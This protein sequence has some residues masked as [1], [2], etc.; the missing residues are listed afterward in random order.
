MIRHLKDRGIE[1]KTDWIGLA[2]SA[3]YGS[4]KEWLPGNY[5]ET[6]R[7][8]TDEFPG[9]HVLLFGSQNEA[10]K[11]DALCRGIDGRVHNLAG[12]LS[13]RQSIEAISLCRLFISND[14]G[15]MHV[16]ASLSIPQVAIFGPTQPHKTAPTSP[17]ARILHHPVHCAPCLHRQCPAGH[18]CMSSVTVAELMEAVD[19]LWQEYPERTEGR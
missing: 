13:L 17:K 9:C 7:Q 8:L 19:A 12:T 18:E 10:R 15:L 11:I 1:R 4:A 5:R 3:A 6:I 2:P 16:A 14:S